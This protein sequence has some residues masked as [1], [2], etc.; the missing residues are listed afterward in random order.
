MDGCDIID[1]Y[2]FRTDKFF[3][4]NKTLECI[5]FS[6]NYINDKGGK[7]LQTLVMHN[8]KIVKMSLRKNCVNLTI[9]GEI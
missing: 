8:K 7:L 2:I 5:D 3:R 9:Q 4:A 1:K 6:N